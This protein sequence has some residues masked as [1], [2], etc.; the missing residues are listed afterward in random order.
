MQRTVRQ[1]ADLVGGT[2]AGDA[3]T[4][5]T[6]VA[7]IERAAVGTIV[8]V[9]GERAFERALASA[10]AAIVAQPICTSGD[11]PI[12]HVSNPKFA[13]ARIVTELV[14]PR[15]WPREV[16]PTASIDGTATLGSEVAVGAWCS[17]GCESAVGDGSVIGNGCSIGHEV[18]IGRNCRIHANVTIH[19]RVRIGDG[20][21][22]HSGAVI[23]G[24]GFGFVVDAGRF[25]KFPQVGDVVIEDDVEIGSNTTID[26]GAL[27]STV[28]GSGTKI[29]NLVQIAHNV[30]IG[31]NCV[32]AAQTGI[33]G[34]ATIEDGVMLGGQV[35]VAD[36][37]RIEA[38]AVAGAQAGI[39]SGKV[40]RKGTMVWG[41]PARPMDQ[42]RKIFALVQN[43]PALKARVTELE[44]R[45]E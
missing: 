40:I 3:D 7:S 15:P 1:L 22:V 10:A 43:L 24:D 16:H 41:T 2:V 14:P 38:G 17:V 6:G 44:R 21:I 11:K 36:H 12:I 28:I 34:S 9:D 25:H 20:V 23:G 19:D 27:D 30:R 33:S 35:G 37:V 45:L 8:F 39:P 26:R 13:F 18:T 32:I 4:V 29:D 31:R 5:I 42:F